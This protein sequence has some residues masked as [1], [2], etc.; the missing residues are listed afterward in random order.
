L[1]GLSLCLFWACNKQEVIPNTKSRVTS[2]PL[3]SREAALNEDDN[4]YRS[5]VKTAAIGLLNLS[6]DAA[7]RTRVT[8]K[9][10]EQFDGETDILLK[11]LKSD[12]QRT[13]GI[14]LT[15]QFSRA[16]TEKRE[17]IQERES[18]RDVLY[19]ENA[20]F[21][22]TEDINRSIDGFECFGET[23]YLHIYI[24]FMSEVNTNERPIIVLGGSETQA[25][26]VPGYQFDEQGILQVINVTEE[27]AQQHLVWVITANESV[28]N[29]GVLSDDAA[30]AIAGNLRAN[31]N[32]H[33]Q[34]NTIEI[35][36]R[37]ECWYCGKAEVSLVGEAEKACD[38]TISL[39]FRLQPFYKLPRTEIGDEIT[40]NKT[41]FTPSANVKVENTL[42]W[43]WYEYDK[44]C[45]AKSSIIPPCNTEF[46]YA[47][48][49]KETPYG[50]QKHY[51]NMLF[52]PGNF[53]WMTSSKY[54]YPNL[55]ANTDSE[56]I[57]KFRFKKT[58]Q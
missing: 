12:V 3:A 37:K 4:L 22:S 42:A 55:D 21:T 39:K 26:T 29:E 25:C 43:V 6:N 2:Q 24:P 5:M 28:N 11:D 48:Q 46:V 33:V 49:E 56:N 13:L 20:P 8:E 10:N 44:G 45:K 23:N 14:N 7:F 57:I 32:Y 35:W 52:D 34:I 19:K 50:V 38:P 36:D 15:E 40:V 58:A 51:D 31:E 53:D 17:T 30:H 41:I 18:E 1:V 16:I 54:A 27:I 9:V 47:I